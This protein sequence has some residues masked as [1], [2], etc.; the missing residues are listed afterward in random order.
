MKATSRTSYQITPT[1]F[2]CES[3]DTMMIL[4]K[5]I[6]QPEQKILQILLGTS[7]SIASNLASV[8]AF[9]IY[10][11]LYLRQYS[12][13]QGIGENTQLLS[14]TNVC[15]CSIDLSNNTLKI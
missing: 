4:T 2:R 12:F 9:F 1:S 14:S 3:F 7:R 5:E 8:D 13:L 6:I 10:S 11:F 15:A